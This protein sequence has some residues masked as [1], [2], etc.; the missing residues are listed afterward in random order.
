MIWRIR[1][2]GAGLM[3]GSSVASAF[4]RIEITDSGAFHP[5]L[6]AHQHANQLRAGLAPRLRQPLHHL[7]D[8]E[9]EEAGLAF[10]VALD[11]GR[12]ARRG[13]RRG[14]GRSSGR[15]RSS[16]RLLFGRERLGDLGLGLL[17]RFRGFGLGGLRAAGDCFWVSS[18]Q[19][20]RRGTMRL[21]TGWSGVESTGSRK[22]YPCR[23]NCSRFRRGLRSQRGG[24]D[25]AV[26]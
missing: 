22:K 17:G 11:F 18:A 25:A 20:S 4:A 9:A 26:G 6:S 5:S 2:S 13:P 19:E 8:Q 21:K 23:S 14:S 10:A 16:S 1:L 3:E 12:G 15:R 24:L 7:G